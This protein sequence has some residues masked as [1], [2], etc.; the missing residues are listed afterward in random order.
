MESNVSFPVL[1]APDS[2][3]GGSYEKYY[4]PTDINEGRVSAFCITAERAKSYAKGFC[5]IGVFRSKIGEKMSYIEGKGLFPLESEDTSIAI[6]LLDETPH[7]YRATTKLMGDRYLLHRYR[8]GELIKVEEY[9]C[10][11][12]FDA[13]LPIRG[14]EERNALK[15]LFHK[16]AGVEERWGADDFFWNQETGEVKVA[17]KRAMRGWLEGYTLT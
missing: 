10:C 4:T 3:R 15:N 2:Y 8:D 16:L 5:K 7:A 14:D 13:F 6:G 17:N 12:H 9:D 1:R 11:C